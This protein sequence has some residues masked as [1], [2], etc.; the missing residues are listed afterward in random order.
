MKYYLQLSSHHT[1]VSTS[2]TKDEILQRIISLIGA[3]GIHK[4]IITWDIEETVLKESQ[5]VKIISNEQSVSI[6]KFVETDR[7]DING[8]IEYNFINS[9]LRFYSSNGNITIFYNDIRI[10][11]TWDYI[12]K[13]PYPIPNKFING[14]GQHK[15]TAIRQFKKWVENGCNKEKLHSNNNIEKEDQNI[16]PDADFKPLLTFSKNIVDG[17]DYENKSGSYD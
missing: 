8:M 14:F 6:T 2:G 7:H 17:G 12:K 16:D 1:G 5:D 4:I 3:E 15:K 11:T 10:D 9:P 13:L